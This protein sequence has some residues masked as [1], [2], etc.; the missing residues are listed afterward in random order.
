MTSGRFKIAV[1]GGV[2]CLLTSTCVL[3]TSPLPKPDAVDPYWTR[4][5]IE[6][7]LTIH[8]RDFS[9]R[10]HAS[11][12]EP[13]RSRLSVEFTAWIGDHALADV[14]FVDSETLTAT[15]IAGLGEGSYDLT[16][17][18]PAGQSGTLT[19]AF[20]VLTRQPP[21]EDADGDGCPDE[22][23]EHP[24]V[25]GPD[26]DGDGTDDDC[27][28]DDDGDSVNDDVDIAPL[29][30]FRCGDADADTCD[31]CAV[32]GGPPLV[33]DDGPD[34]DGDGVCDQGG[35][36]LEIFEAPPFGD[37]TAFAFLVDY[38][39]KIYLGPTRDGSGAVRVNPD[40]SAP[41][42]ISFAFEP[43]VGE[44][45]NSCDLPPTCT[46]PYPS[47]GHTGCTL[48]SAECGPDNENGRGLFWSGRM[49]GN[50]WLAIAGS[51]VGERLRYIYMTTD[52]GVS[53]S[54]AYLRID[55]VLGGATRSVSAAH[56]L[57]GDL[58]MGL[59][60]QGGRRPYVVVL[61]TEPTNPG[62][63]AIPPDDIESLHAEDIVRIGLDGTPPNPDPTGT[64][65]ID[66]IGEFSERLYLANNGGC[67]RATVAAPRQP[68]DFVDCTPS[69]AAYA[70]EESIAT[71]K[72][73]DIEPAD[74]AT[75]QMAAFGGRL[76]MGRNTT[77]GPQLW[78]CEPGQDSHCDPEDWS[79]IASS[80]VH[81]NLSQ[82]DN[83]NNTRVTLIVA[84]PTHLWVG[85]DNSVD[86]LV[87]FR[88][89]TTNP[90]V[91]ADF[92][93]NLGCSAAGH[94]TTCEGLSK[95]GFGAADNSRILDSAAIDV[96]GQEF[97]Y[98]VTGDGASEVRVFR[99]H[100]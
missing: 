39:G 65:I 70:A 79:L 5:G 93:G 28:P 43:E 82:F 48:G 49:G 26:T 27:D 81:D 41:E 47:I 71:G 63:A 90:T 72:I 8:G 1:A 87:V 76:Y 75:P 18:D 44:H 17:I 96:G 2:F 73:A 29:D 66:W 54:L 68:G 98:L 94:P 78:S 64:L 88:S 15:L 91:R 53:L 74:R 59:P 6:T 86:G 21:N 55:A 33:N 36:L 67:A 69:A 52:T 38:A 92:S 7:S 77:S 23:D 16:V 4:E 11:F 83:P 100:D 10:R 34:S 20:T 89:A 22:S 3:R 35:A 95:N 37:G 30:R 40:G 12:V 42:S 24:F 9:P 14:T 57:G 51:L 84:T 19:T 56:F 61:E 13:G 97:L 31:D 58:Y 32:S 62:F 46:P 25:D 85:F 80:P 50:E 60:D 45:V 99:L